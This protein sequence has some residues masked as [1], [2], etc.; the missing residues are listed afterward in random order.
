MTLVEAL[1]ALAL[2]AVCLALAMPAWRDAVRAQRVRAACAA[3]ADALRLARLEA[4]QA[5]SQ[6]LLCP[7]RD[8]SSC[9]EWARWEQGWVLRVGDDHEALRAVQ[10]ELDGVRIDAPKPLAHGA[11]FD[12]EGWPRQPAGQLLMGRWRICASGPGRPG[13]GLELVMAASG[14]LREQPADC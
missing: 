5:G 11:S 7:S 8:G 12:A 2:S 9:D 6:A 10:H 14:R 13:R 3:L 1:T 4:R